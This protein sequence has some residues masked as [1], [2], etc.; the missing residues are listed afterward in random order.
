MVAVL[1]VVAGI[2]CR[3][4]VGGQHGK[5]DMDERA[6]RAGELYEIAPENASDIAH[7]LPAHLAPPGIRYVL[8]TKKPRGGFVKSIVMIESQDDDPAVKQMSIPVEKIAV[9]RRVTDEET[10]D[11]V[12]A[13]FLDTP[14]YFV[15]RPRDSSGADGSAD[16]GASRM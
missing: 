9:L 15:D 11:R 1:S 2:F 16:D 7:V 8:A 6:E 4:L 3:R 14:A 10:R 12:L 5:T 13:H